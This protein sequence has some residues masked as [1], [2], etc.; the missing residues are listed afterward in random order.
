MIQKLPTKK[1]STSAGMDDV[2]NFTK[3]GQAKMAKQSNFWSKPPVKKAVVT[4][5]VP[6]G[7][8]SRITH[9]PM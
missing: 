9:K 4:K 5:K 6:T 8:M 3:A 7:R 2:K 1:A